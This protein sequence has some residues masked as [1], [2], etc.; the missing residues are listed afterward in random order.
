MPTQ[1]PSLNLSDHTGHGNTL[2]NH[3]A[4]L[5]SSV[6]TG[7]AGSVHSAELDS[8]GD[9]LEAQDS[10]SLDITGSLTIE[11]WVYITGTNGDR[12][13]VSKDDGN[14]SYQAYIQSDQSITL[15]VSATGAHNPGNGFGYSVS[16]IVP[17]NTWTF[18][19]FVYTPSTVAIY[20]NGGSVS[21]SQSSVPNSIYAGTAPLMINYTSAGIFGV[22]DISI[23]NTARS[24]S[25]IASDMH[26]QF[27]GS[28]PGLVAYYLF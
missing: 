18:L 2:T 23:W 15:N 17:F 27:T 6:P 1:P 14:L 21:V 12:Y 19:T 8:T 4:T 9:Y 16:N 24:S 5:S 20:V 3:G 13:L 26:T 10:P 11:G 7:L 25:Q 22:D 28:E